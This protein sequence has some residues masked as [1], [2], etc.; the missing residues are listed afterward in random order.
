M[1]QFRQGEE[2]RPC[3]QAHYLAWRVAGRLGYTVL[4]RKGCSHN[5]P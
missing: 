4:L 3:A 1:D 5:T 2:M